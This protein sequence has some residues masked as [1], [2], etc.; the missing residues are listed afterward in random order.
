VN[1]WV[2]EFSS[3]FKAQIKDFCS[4]HLRQAKQ[5]NEPIDIQENDYVQNSNVW[6]FVVPVDYVVRG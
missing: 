6:Y 1:S 2:S 3:D 5:N 4:H